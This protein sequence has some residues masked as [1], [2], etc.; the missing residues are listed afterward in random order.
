[1]SHYLDDK[2][3]A[4]LIDA[5]LNVEPDVVTGR[6]EADGIKI[7]LG[8][9]GDIWPSTIRADAALSAGIVRL[10]Y[11]SSAPQPNRI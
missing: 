7:A 1:M 3:Y 6:V 8:E 4:R 2:T 11:S 9:I 10:V 5:L